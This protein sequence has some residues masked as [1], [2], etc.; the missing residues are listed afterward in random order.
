VLSKQ[1][2]KNFLS[3]FLS[4]VIGQLFILWAFVH[5]AKVFGPEGFGKFSF[6]Q[7]F[8]LYFLSFADFGLQTLGTRSIAQEKNNI[9][10]QVWNITLLRIILALV[11][12]LILLLINIFLP[13]PADVKT[14]IVIFGF[15][16]IPSAVLL[17]WVFQGI[18]QM[19]YVGIGRVVRGIT[20]AGLVFI[21]VRTPEHL[22][23]AVLYY[24][25]SITI[26]SMILLVIY[27]K[28]FGMIRGKIEYALLG[29][30]L[31]TAIPLAAGSLITQIN[32]NFGVFA[33]GI[34]KSDEIVGLFSAAYKIILFL[35][36]FVV[37]AASN[38]ILPTLARSYQES[39]TTFGNY[40]KS[41]SRVFI[42][43]AVPLGV[44]GSIL[45]PK[46]MSFLYPPEFQKAT[47]VFQISIWAVVIIIYRIIFENA[48]IASKNQRRYFIGY[49]MAGIL[50][51][52]G[53]ILLVPS[54]GLLAPSIV[55][56][57][58][59]VSL[60][61]YFVLSTKFVHFS[62]IVEISGIPL[63]ASFLMGMVLYFLALNL[64]L[65]II[66]GII[67]YLGLLMCFKYVTLEELAGY[68]R[69]WV[70]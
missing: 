54:L 6:A 47:I 64:F 13:I 51:I 32:Y 56:V 23:Y 22:N 21:F 26:A 8:T 24:V 30:L 31:V 25:V 61:F 66:V 49:I 12:F 5:I 37:V 14:L 27:F 38:A 7:V 58:S 3:L 59:E 68:A 11:C 55:G 70:H 28:N 39:T 43:I 57:I 46:I 35:W 18:E 67:L 53:N 20:F 4:N 34:L 16:I 15:A 48:L 44:G 36:A 19:E 45:A 2:T 63:A 62:Y 42:M 9:P 52:L 33:L 17:E 1:I 40:L 65:L 50:T 69:S 10:W 41:L 60:L 29:K